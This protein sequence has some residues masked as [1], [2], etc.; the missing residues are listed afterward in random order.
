MEKQV[1]R[2]ITLVVVT[3]LFI[4]SLIAFVTYRI[5]NG[6]MD[7][8]GY[9]IYEIVC[10]VEEPMNYTIMV[11]VPFTARG[12]MFNISELKVISG[13][14]SIEYYNSDYGLS[15]KIE[16]NGRVVIH[17][18]KSTDT[19]IK[20]SMSKE[21]ISFNNT[22]FEGREILYWIYMD[23]EVK[24]LDISICCW[25]KDYKIG[26]PYVYIGGNLSSSGWQLIKGEYGA[27]R[28]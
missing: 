11:P 8:E 16:A 18:E 22:L 7:K 5:N 9:Y 10:D 15:L 23:G 26:Y 28:V 6:S 20:F 19:L 21:N 24:Q 2:L 13:I 17:G 3:G 4:L 25:E 27:R 14:A 12:E 1:F